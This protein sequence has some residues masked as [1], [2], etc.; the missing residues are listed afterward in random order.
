MGRAPL[1][2]ESP[3][4]L[5]GYVISGVH[6]V[7]PPVAGVSRLFVMSREKNVLGEAQ[8]NEWHLLRGIKPLSFQNPSPSSQAATQIQDSQLS[9]VFRNAGITAI[10]RSFCFTFIQSRPASGQ[11][12]LCSQL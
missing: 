8:E 12:S 3:G 9:S 6:S 11:L 5:F 4:V 1:C 2:G 10:A 7:F